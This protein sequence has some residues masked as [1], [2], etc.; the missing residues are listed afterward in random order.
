[1]KK[2]VFVLI[3]L[4]AFF[5]ISA[6]QPTTGDGFEKITFNLTFI[7]NIQ[8]A[9]IYVAID[10]GFFAEE[11]L[12]IELVYGNEADMVALV[13]SNH[14]QF[15]I[16]SGEQL[17]LSREQ[18]L[19]V[20]SV[21]TWYKDYPVGVAALK[22]ANITEPADLIGKD[23]GLPGLYG[24]NYIGMEA[25]AAQTGLANADYKLVSIGFTQV[26]TLVSGSVD[27][28]VVY[29]ANEP[30][31]LRARGYEIDVMAVQDYIELV[32]NCLVSNETTVENN[33]ELVEKMVRSFRKGLEYSAANPD[34]AWTIS[35]KYVDNL[36]DEVSPI[37]KEVLAESIKLWQLTP[38]TEAEQQVRWTNMLDILIEIGLINN[39]LNIQ[40]VY[41]NEFLP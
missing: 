34:E 22:E 12:E 23:I 24:A 10:K 39:R 16:A 30:V 32:G 36:T 37:Q 4:V 11:G 6:C 17:L 41:T 2:N 40:D 29:L 31:Q 18:G 15:M 1:M 13:G 25:L 35:Q 7:P 38:E 28:V 33:P 3:V 19:P 21:A 20:V 8:F 14:Q 26:E 5:V 27:A 9:P